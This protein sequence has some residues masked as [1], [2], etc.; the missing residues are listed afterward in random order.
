MKRN[1]LYGG[2]KMKN[3]SEAVLFKQ[4]FVKQRIYSKIQVVDSSEQ[5]GRQF[6]VCDPH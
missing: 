3:A 5:D 1:K 6:S 2:A 4:L